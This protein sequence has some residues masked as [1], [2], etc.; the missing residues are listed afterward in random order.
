[1]SILVTPPFLPIPFL[2]S[3]L[4]LLRLSVLSGN[5]VIARPVLVSEKF[6]AFMVGWMGTIYIGTFCVAD[7]QVV[8]RITGPLSL[9]LFAV[10]SSLSAFFSATLTL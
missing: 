9:W 6:G 10:C 1:M 8:E 2:L 3:C 5:D 4:L 7:D